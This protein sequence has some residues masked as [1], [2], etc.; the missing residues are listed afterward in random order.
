MDFQQALNHPLVRAS[1]LLRMGLVAE[2]ASLC[3]EKRKAEAALAAL[4][5]R[6]AHSAKPKRR[7]T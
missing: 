1:E 4:E 6:L 7:K 3:M 2:L 5:K